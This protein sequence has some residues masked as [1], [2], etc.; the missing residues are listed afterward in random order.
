[1]DIL[2]NKRVHIEC[3]HLGGS[4]HQSFT[5]ENSGRAM[6]RS[7]EICQESDGNEEMKC[8]DVLGC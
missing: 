3:W 4:R 2:E 5:Y 8:Y 1:M 6:N 7:P